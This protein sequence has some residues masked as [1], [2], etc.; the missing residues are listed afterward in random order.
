MGDNN[1]KAV[2]FLGAAG[3]L[4]AL[5]NPA[6]WPIVAAGA[7]AGAIIAACKRKKSPPVEQQESEESDMVPVRRL[8]YY[9]DPYPGPT[10]IP[11][12]ASRSTES[13]L[14]SVGRREPLRTAELISGMSTDE[15]VREAIRDMGSQFASQGRGMQFKIKRNRK[16]TKAKGKIFPC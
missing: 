7:G 4:C 12:L 16:G 10:A 2:G 14:I 3:A 8:P 5:F 13:P 1:A 15:T 11:H 6:S 9:D